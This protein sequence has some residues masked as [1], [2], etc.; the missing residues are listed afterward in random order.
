MAADILRV[1]GLCKSF[2]E[3]VVL[4]N[5]SF[6]VASNSIVGIVGENGAGKSTLFNMISGIVRPDRG[7]IEYRGKEIHPANYKEA[8]LLGIS[9]VFQEQALI[10]NIAVYENI[11]L[12]HEAHFAHFGQILDRRRMIEAAQRIVDSMKLDVDVRRQTSDYD[13]SKRQSIEIARACLVPRE[14]L[15][16]S[17]PLVLLDEPTSALEKSEEEALFRL[18]RSI[19]EHGSVLFVSHR[20]GEVLSVC[21]IIHVLKDGRLVATVSPADVDE[22]TLH[23]LM[24]GRE[25]DSDYYHE[26]EQ[27]RTADRP[28]Y[29]GGAWPFACR[30]L[31]G[32]VVRDTG[33]RSTWDRWVA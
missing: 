21:D 25:R 10:P 12:S 8:N 30:L 18:I 9:R 5:V 33:R 28:S 6:S 24:V 29:A 27:G 26:E 2:G 19:K 14:V 20:L 31:Q 15:S 22:R 23:G 16:I 3:A 4:D 7:R 32:C 1:E 11:L 13:F 17:A